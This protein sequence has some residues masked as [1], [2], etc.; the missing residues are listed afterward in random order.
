MLIRRLPVILAIVTAACHASPTGPPSGLPVTLSWASLPP[1][2]PPQPA[3]ITAAGD[4]VVV[5]RGLSGVRIILC[6]FD[7]RASRKHLG[8]DS[9]RMRDLQM[10]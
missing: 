1:G 6:S 7:I 5:A 10:W 8:Q 3:T 9:G 4:S 2:A